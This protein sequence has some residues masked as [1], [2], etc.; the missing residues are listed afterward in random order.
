MKW[1]KGTEKQ[2]PA[3]TLVHIRY[4]VN[5]REFKTTGFYEGG[6][7]YRQTGSVMDDCPDIEYLDEAPDEPLPTGEQIEKGA[8]T[9]VIGKYGE[10]ADWQ[11][12]QGTEKQFQD[13]IS[14]AWVAGASQYA[15]RCRELEADRDYYKKAY[16]SLLRSIPGDD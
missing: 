11:L 15:G 7:W 10:P 16:S 8:H 5:G 14:A 9:Y 3:N 13:A 4:F 1:R 6:E 12:I 2:P